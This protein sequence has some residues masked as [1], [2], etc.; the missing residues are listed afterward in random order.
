[1]LSY[2]E[3]LMRHGEH[4]LL[5]IVE[6]GEKANAIRYRAAPSIEERWNIL[7]NDH[8]GFHGAPAMSLAA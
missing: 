1:M 5:W 6:E 3:Y 2:D 7:F 4:G 8:G